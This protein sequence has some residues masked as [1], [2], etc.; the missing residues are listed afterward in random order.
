MHPIRGLAIVSRSDLIFFQPGHSSALGPALV[1]HHVGDFNRPVL[2][3]WA[4]ALRH[5]EATRTRPVNVLSVK[6]SASVSPSVVPCWPAAVVPV[7][8]R[9]SLPCSFNSS[10]RS[11]AFVKNGLHNRNRFDIFLQSNSS[12]I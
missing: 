6:P 8:N 2:D 1:I 3:S 7:H 10:R 5:R 11:R 9:H 4:H 12:A